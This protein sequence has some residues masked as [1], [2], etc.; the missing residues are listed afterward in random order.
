MHGNSWEWCADWY[1]AEYYGKSPE[2][3]PQGPKKAS[4]RVRRGGSWANAA[5]DCRSAYRSWVVPGDRG[6]FL[7]FRVAAVPLSQS[8]AGAEPGT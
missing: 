4:L 3:D 8:E 7:G 6:S 5:K 1:D 2:V